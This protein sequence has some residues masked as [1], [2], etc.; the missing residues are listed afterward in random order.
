MI[1]IAKKYKPTLCKKSRKIK[2]SGTT[3]HLSK[4][5]D[6]RTQISLQ[7]VKLFRRYCIMELPTLSDRYRVTYLAWP[8]SCSAPNTKNALNCYGVPNFELDKGR[9]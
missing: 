5:I 6:T 8:L 2:F 3:F 9:K 4:K 1:T 7:L